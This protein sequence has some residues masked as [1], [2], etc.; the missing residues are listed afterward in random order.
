MTDTPEFIIE[1]AGKN[2]AYYDLR[3][4][5]IILPNSN[6]FQSATRLC[7]TS[8]G[9]GQCTRAGS[10]GQPWS[11]RIEVGFVSSHYAR[12][13]I[14]SMMTGDRIRLGHDPLRHSAYVGSG[15]P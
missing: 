2:R 13:G 10:T 14:S 4:D 6:Q 15:C 5:R 12:E 11:K 8:W 7:R 1:N 9:T 3:W